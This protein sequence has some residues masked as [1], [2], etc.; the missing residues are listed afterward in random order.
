M[1]FFNKYFGTNI[2]PQFLKQDYENLVDGY[3][4][5]GIHKLSNQYLNNTEQSA[6]TSSFVA[7]S[8]N[9]NQQK[10]SYLVESFFTYNDFLGKARNI[11]FEQDG[12]FT[13]LSERYFAKISEGELIGPIRSYS[14]FT[15]DENQILT[16]IPADESQVEFERCSSIIDNTY[17]FPVLDSLSQ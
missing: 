8:P 6:I 13:V 12:N 1:D 17:S 4:K 9:I 15:L 10:T 16:E 2:S 14:G 3:E 5:P 11:S 7:V